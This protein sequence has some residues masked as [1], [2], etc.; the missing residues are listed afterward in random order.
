MK[1]LEWRWFAINSARGLCLVAAVLG[2][3]LAGAAETRPQYGGTLHIAMHAA[4][5]SLDPADQNL[6]DSFA[7]RSLMRLIFDTLIA[8]D[9]NGRMQAF[10]AESWQ[11]VDADRRWQFRLRHGVKFDDG[12]SLTAEIAAAS[13]RT[14]N[15]L[16]KVSTEGDSVIIEPGG[17]DP[18]L[19]AELALA[20]NAIVKRNTDG[21]L[22]GTGAFHVVDW[23]P[24][25]RVTLAAEENCWR[26]RPFLDGIEIEMGRSYRDQAMALE[27]GRA[28]MIEVPAEQAHRAGLE[29]RTVVSSLPVELLALIFRTDAASPTEKTLRESLALS[30][31][32]SSIRNV[33]LQGAGQPAGGILPTWMSGYGFVFPTNADLARARHDREQVRNISV[34]SLGYDVSDPLARLLAERVV[35]NA[36]DAGLTV[37]PSATASPDLR[38]MRIPL[39]SANPWI[40]LEGAAG[41]AGSSAMKSRTGSV[42]ELY[43]A[44]RA[45]LATQ[46]MIPLFHLPASYAAT[47]ALKNWTVQADGS[48]DLTSAWLRSTQP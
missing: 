38:L 15:P 40:A 28:D 7:R 30:V 44:E 5:T 39:V 24:A 42:E 13:L 18:E 47:A 37:Q 3:A 17:S 4:P 1:R 2:S 9:R 26:G 11:A 29:G 27:S 10:L 21:Q 34:W 25:K 8:A 33:L 16:W 48:L 20:R 12:T 31:E 23:Q 19:L 22:G 32:R 41:S 35:L 45:A 46:R 36:R 6:T 14:A 43:A